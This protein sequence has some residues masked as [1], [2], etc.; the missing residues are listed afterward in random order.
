MSGLPDWNLEPPEVC[1]ECGQELRRVRRRWVCGCQD[2]QDFDG[3]AE[4][5]DGPVVDRDCDY[6]QGLFK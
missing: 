3:Y 1:D 4:Y 2:D 5:S 6:W